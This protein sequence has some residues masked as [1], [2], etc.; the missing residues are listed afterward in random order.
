MPSSIGGFLGGDDDD[1]SDGDDDDHSASVMDAFDDEYGYHAPGEYGDDDEEEGNV[2]EERDGLH[3]D[4]S[5]SGSASS[6]NSGG[7]GGG[8]LNPHHRRRSA[9]RRLA[10]AGLEAA[11]RSQGASLGALASAWREVLPSPLSQRATGHL[12]DAC[13]AALSS[14]VMGLPHISEPASRALAHLMRLQARVLLR[15][16]P[17]VSLQYLPH[18][19]RH[20]AVSRLLDA[21]LSDIAAAAAAGQYRLLL[22]NEELAGL[23]GALFQPSQQREALLRRLRQERD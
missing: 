16:L 8:G 14:D 10:P 15:A 7:E 11:V 3:G 19:E 17:G 18:L 4:S 21:R 9:T 2:T 13:L 20:A 5:S 12:A 6:S 1:V 23:V 22:S